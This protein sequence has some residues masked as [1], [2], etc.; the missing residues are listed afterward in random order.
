[1]V[2]S[3]A[4]LA[5]FALGIGTALSLMGDATLYAVL[6]THPADAGIPLA[7][8]GII[9]SINRIIRLVTNGPAGWLYDRAR[10]RRLIFVSSLA[11]GVLSTAL[12][13][14]SSSFEPIFTARLLWGTAW[15]GI[16]VGGNA[17]VLEMA[18]DGARG[19]WIGIYQVW[20]FF[21]SALGSF[22]GGILTDAFGYHNALWIGAIIS[23]AGA[24]IAAI[25]LLNHSHLRE[26]R[27]PSHSTL[28]ARRPIFLFDPRRISVPVWAIVASH[29]IN[30]LVVA[31]V[32]T[33]TM[34]LLIQNL[35]GNSFGVASITGG[36]LAART[37]ASLVSAGIFGEWS[38]R[39]G[40]RWGLLIINLA[41]GAAGML[42][43]A[44]SDWI[45]LLIGALVG[46]IASG[47]IQSL[48]TAMVGDL[49]PSMERGRNLGIFN[50]A[51]DLGSAIGPLAAFAL[52][53]VTGLGAVFVICAALMTS[54]AVFVY[55]IRKP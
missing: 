49:S 2:K 25:G 12:Y 7:S 18:P 47:G 37:L 50:T 27:P 17:I 55:V 28:L 15:S 54:N 39:I 46:A 14:L 6:P 33:S 51:G 43:V 5:I 52:L 23:A 10:D 13:A 24:I 32:V 26:A 34:G 9:L 3:T 41:L 4:F 35:Q 16:W 36:L 40:S 48:A 53:P 19:R 42:L 38:D 30:R 44:I 29:G 20:F 45:A 21:G 31:G 1:M 11:I 22:L 8:V